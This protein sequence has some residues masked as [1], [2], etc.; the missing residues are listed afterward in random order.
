[1]SVAGTTT[2]IAPE[3]D[4]ANGMGDAVFH[5]RASAD[6]YCAAGPTPNASSGARF[7]VPAGEFVTV[8]V[9]GGDKL[10]WIAA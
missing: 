2:S 3:V 4:G 7:F 9:N 10:A 6:S 1:M 8:Y 5:V